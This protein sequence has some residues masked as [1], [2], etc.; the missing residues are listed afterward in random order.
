MQYNNDTCCSGNVDLFN[1]QQKL[2]NEMK[3]KNTLHFLHCVNAYRLILIKY[4]KVIHSK[5]SE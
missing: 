3:K 4:I 1:L 2:N 5:S